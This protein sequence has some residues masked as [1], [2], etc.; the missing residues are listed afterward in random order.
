MVRRLFI[1]V[2]GN[3]KTFFHNLNVY[4]MLYLYISQPASYNGA[5]MYKYYMIYP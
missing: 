2:I 1:C 3:V 4:I 5:D